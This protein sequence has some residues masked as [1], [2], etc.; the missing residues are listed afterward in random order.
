MI[1]DIQ[2]Q[3][4]PA[5]S[6]SPPSSTNSSSNIAVPRSKQR[7]QPVYFVL[8]LVSSVFFVTS[9][10]L[11]TPSVRITTSWTRSS[12]EILYEFSCGR[13]HESKPL[14]GAAVR[15]RFGDDDDDG[16]GENGENEDE[17]NSVIFRTRCD[18]RRRRPG[19]VVELYYDPSNPSDPSSVVEA[20]FHSL[21]LSPL[22]CF[23][24]GTMFSLVT[25]C[26][27]YL[28]LP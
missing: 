26:H 28:A 20:D 21:W 16:G 10:F 7:L 13:G 12:G 24:L 22:L 23:C 8:I 15:Y 17:E 27:L 9:I 14:Y 6:F 4:P 3:P 18:A 5:A 19:D 1:S 2:N 11:A 25:G